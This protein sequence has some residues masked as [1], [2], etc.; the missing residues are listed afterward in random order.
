MCFTSG[1][2][3]LSGSVFLSYD[4]VFFKPS[5]VAK[6]CKGCGAKV[7]VHTVQRQNSCSIMWLNLPLEAVGVMR[8]HASLYIEVRI[9]LLKL[10]ETCFNL[11]C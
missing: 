3:T 10:N 9:A 6:E 7:H 5:Q 1:S 11:V 2:V 8:V 4:C